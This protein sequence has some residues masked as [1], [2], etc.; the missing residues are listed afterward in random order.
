MLRPMPQ[1][2]P[3]PPPYGAA[4]RVPGSP[5]RGRPFLLGVVAVVAVVVVI[6]I[7]AAATDSGG[8]APSTHPGTADA[9]L[10]ADSAADPGE[11]AGAATQPGPPPTSPPGPPPTTN[12]TNTAG[13]NTGS[14]AAPAAAAG[15]VDAECQRLQ[16]E[17]KWS[18]LEQCADKLTPL[19]ARRAAELRTR[20]VEEARTAPR[21]TAFEAALR[22][23][24]LKRARTELDQVWPGSV[25]H[26]RLAHEYEVA[27]SQAIAA[28]AAELASV[29]ESGGDKYNALLATERAARPPRV[30]AEAARRTPCAP[31]ASAS[32]PAPP[33]SPPQPA[34]CDVDALANRGQ[35]Q[36]AAG[37]YAAALA[38]YEA[39]H[40][41]KPSPD[42]SEK[43]FVL[44]C[45]LKNLPKARL[46][47]RRLL[48][49]MK[50]RA[51]MICVRN[52]IPEAKLNAP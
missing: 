49:A 4:A 38:S 39:A 44:A 29:K 35:N 33:P 45:N 12:T 18:E 19:D 7:V 42:L 21:I 10:P 52:G 43:L 24:D 1:L 14:A 5:P 51:L 48:P 34:K 15:A 37:Q 20:A 40:A 22:A 28:L 17:R 36:Y 50:S 3:E 47:W 23:G 27:E 16:D 31:A 46:H 8:P 32:A 11:S 9:P 13:A 41:C 25:E 30:A 2:S 6:A 26:P